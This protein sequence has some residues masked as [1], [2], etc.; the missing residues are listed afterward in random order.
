MIAKILVFSVFI[1]GSLAR[2][3]LSLAQERQGA[4]QLSQPKVINESSPTN[5][6]LSQD[7]LPPS[8]TNETSREKF[9]IREFKIVGNT[10]FLTEQ[11]LQLL[12][13][14]QNQEFL[15]SQLPNIASVITDFYNK[16]EYLTSFAFVQNIRDNIATI[17]VIEG[18]IGQIEL[19]I[20]K[21]VICPLFIKDRL[22]H[23]EN[24][25]LNSQDIKTAIATLYFNDRIEYINYDLEKTETD[26]LDS[27]TLKVTA[28]TVSRFNLAIGTDNRRNPFLGETTRRVAIGLNSILVCGDLAL[29]GYVGTRG[30]EGGDFLYAVPIGSNDARLTLKTGINSNGVIANPFA[31]A[32]PETN[33]DYVEVDFVYPL[34]QSPTQKLTLGVVFSR[35]S[36]QSFILDRGV[37]ISKG[38]DDF[39]RLKDLVI[40][41][42][43]SYIRRQPGEKLEFYSQFSLGSNV[44]KPTVSEDQPDSNFFIWQ[45]EGKYSRYLNKDILLVVGGFLQFTP[46]SL[47]ALE[48]AYLGGLDSVRG[49]RVA[50]VTGDNAAR[51]SFEVRFIVWKPK[52]NMEFQIVPFFDVGTGW[53]NNAA[54][55]LEDN[56]IASTGLELRFVIFEKL[57]AR[58]G[59]GVPWVNV[60]DRNITNSFQE[61]GGYFSFIWRALEF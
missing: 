26:R 11:L 5:S 39:G 60:R 19:E 25:P 31:E 42:P 32:N 44:F 6:Q 29:A 57:E 9:F 8:I 41:F 49:Y 14:Y 4:R 52:E 30:T 16:N 59:V 50:I 38:A 28:D 21:G 15:Q 17:Q 7:N 33:F 12:A 20:K 35:L 1:F 48:Q 13:P 22:R 18:Q 36:S 37:P 46:D 45:G 54:T 43:Q 55:T 56:F 58:L 53:N 24:K 47:T 34:I 27:T 61:K 10:V 23:L 2:P 3:D 40:R 51:G